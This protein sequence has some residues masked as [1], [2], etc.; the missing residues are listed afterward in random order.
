MVTSHDL[1]LS[2]LTVVESIWNLRIAWIGGTWPLLCSL[3]ALRW[4]SFRQITYLLLFLIN[5]GVQ[6]D[7]RSVLNDAQCVNFKAFGKALYSLEPLCFAQS[8][9]ILWC[10]YCNCSLR[11]N[12]TVSALCRVHERCKEARRVSGSG[13]LLLTYST[14]Y[15]HRLHT[16]LSIYV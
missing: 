1:T 13:M 3:L 9:E 12:I 5:I 8:V 16:R 6:D 2:V 7:T 11:R 14:G 10:S 15:V 4:V